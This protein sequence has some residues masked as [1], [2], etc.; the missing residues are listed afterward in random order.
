MSGGG[1]VEVCL[2]AVNE[3]SPRVG[4]GRRGRGGEKES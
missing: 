2:D 1:M 3:R 4:G